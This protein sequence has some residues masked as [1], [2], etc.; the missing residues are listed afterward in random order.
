MTTPPPSQ[1]RAKALGR[2]GPR[3]MRDVV[4]RAHQA[5]RGAGARRHPHPAVEHALERAIAGLE[6]H[7]SRDEAVRL[8]AQAIAAEIVLG[9]MPADVGCQRISRLAQSAPAAL[10]EH[11]WIE[12]ADELALAEEGVLGRE[13]V[14][15]RIRES[16][17]A[18]LSL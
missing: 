6:A 3:A 17:E 4:N 15:A 12:L 9:A 11:P 18:L 10:D 1:L 13:G 7:P 14:Q 16:A 5:L 8:F 2:L